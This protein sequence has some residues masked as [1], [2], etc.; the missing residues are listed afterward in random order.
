MPDVTA[1]KLHIQN[2][3]DPAPKEN[4]QLYT[5][6]GINYLLTDNNK[7][8]IDKQP[9]EIIVSKE[10]G[11]FDSLEAAIDSIT[12]ITII[13][14]Y[15]GIYS[16]TKINTLPQ[17]CSI[18]GQGN[19]SNIVVAGYLKTTLFNEINNISIAGGGFLHD[20][21]NVL[22]FSVIKN[23][24]I[25]SCVIGIDVF[26]GLGSLFVDTIS[27]FQTPIGIKNTAGSII[28]SSVIIQYSSDSALQLNG[29]TTTIDTLSCYYSNLA[30]DIFNQA[31]VRGSLFYISEN[32]A[33][34]KVGKDNSN[35]SL[36]LTFLNIDNT[37]KPMII[38]SVSN[39]EI[40]NG[41][42]DVSAIEYTIDKINIV[43][44]IQDRKYNKN[45]QLLTGDTYIGY[46][47]FNSKLLVGNIYDQNKLKI[48][49][50]TTILQNDTVGSVTDIYLK[51]TDK[52]TGLC[53]GGTL[54]SIL[55]YYYN[56]TTWT[57][58]RNYNVIPVTGKNLVYFDMTY[59]PS[60][61]TINGVLAK[62]IKLTLN[63]TITKITLHSNAIS[64]EDNQI[65]CYGSYR[66]K[67]MI[68][69][70]KTVGTKYFLAP[71]DFDYSTPYTIYTDLDTTT[72]IPNST[73]LQNFTVSGLILAYVN[74]EYFSIYF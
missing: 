25:S 35:C 16:L 42:M 47:N 70:D 29:G 44:N 5:Q 60:N 30:A 12:G 41:N 53:I 57:S 61:V 14:L 21:S 51:H 18:V 32:T 26:G 17:G 9:E 7:I 73:R 49:T 33:G 48:S 11:Q 52:I 34:I 28:I 36:V 59:N 15:P 55:S 13:K 4:V 50:T 10:S 24:I 27:I 2:Y 1:L 19:A 63:T 68:Y 54:S 74:V 67:K 6:A 62:W 64:V 43:G 20:G 40:Y 66:K 39:L 56:G 22:S 3:V 38:N 23:C 72:Q 46:E 8:L 58:L 37:T 45:F 31:T 71:E 69:L 65:K